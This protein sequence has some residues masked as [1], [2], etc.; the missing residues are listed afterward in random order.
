MSRIISRAESWEKVYTAFQNINFAAFDFN[1]IKQSLLEYIK[2]TFPETFNDYIES[3]ELIAIVESFAYI[4]ELLAYRIDVNAHENFIPTAQR[5]DSV[6][7]L[8]KLVSYTASR[9]LP[10]RGLVKLVSVSTT[11]SVI[12]ANGVDLA[13]QVIRWNDLS[14]VDWKEQFIL[15]INRVLDQQFGSVSPFDRFQIQDVL[16]ELYGVNLI[17][18]QRGVFPYGV[19]VNGNSLSMELVPV[20]YDDTY[21]IVERRPEVN[22]NFTLLYGSD[23]NGDAS[24]TTGF[25]CY[26]K[27]GT[28]QRFAADFDGITPNQVYEINATQI[29]DTDVW[30]NGVNPTTRE[31]VDVPPDFS[32]RIQDGRS[33]EWKQV[34]LAHAQNI[35]FNTNP[36]RNKYEVETRDEN[37]I[38]IIFGDGEF[39]DIPGGSFDIWARSSEDSDVV[40]PQSSVV[41]MPMAFTYVDKFNRTQTF[42]FTFTLINSLQNASASEDLEHIRNTAPAVYYTQDRMVNGEDYNVFMMQDP[43]IMKLRAV[44]RTF[45]GDS[46]YIP[47]H[48]TSQSY[49]NVK[50]FGDDAYL[51]YQTKEVVETTP[52]VDINTLIDGY[53]EPLLSS[54]DIVLQLISAGVSS[55]DIRRVFTSEEKTQ[56]ADTLFPPPATVYLFYNKDTNGWTAVRASDD[57]GSEITAPDGNYI[58]TWLIHIRQPTSLEEIYDVSRYAKRLMAESPTTQFWNTNDADKVIDYN[59]LSSV[60]DQIAILRANSNHTRDGILSQN[61]EFDVLGQEVLD[62]G[63]QDIHRLVVL[64]VDENGDGVPDNLDPTDITNPQGVAEIFT[65]KIRLVGGTPANTNITI[66][67]YFTSSSDIRVYRTDTGADLNYGTN[68]IEILD[69]DNGIGNKV[70]FLSTV[71]TGTDVICEVKEYVYFHRSTTSAPWVAV[72]STYQTLVNYKQDLINLPENR[73]WQRFEGKDQLNFLWTHYSPRYHLVDPSPSNIIDTFVITKGYYTSLQRWLEDPLA[74]TPRTPTP[75]DLRT[76]YNYLLDNKMISDTVI[77]HPGKIKLLFGTRAIPE[78]RATFKVI[79]SQN[80]ILTDNQIKTVVVNT[81]RNFFDI[82]QWEFGE[83]FYFTELAAVIHLAL[84]SDISSV[85]LVP[86]IASNQFGDLFQVLAREDEMF[87]PDITVSQVDIVTSYTSLNMRQTKSTTTFITGTCSGSGGT[88]ARTPYCDLTYCDPEYILENSLAQP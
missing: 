18:V 38:R 23:G 21:G 43:S 33:G 88:S 84:P 45:A 81:I 24:D 79:K 10:A 25:F 9:P 4:A 67:V 62:S 22:S 74:P 70:R 46:K 80:S 49:E 42:S 63:L 48:D 13:N 19:T 76:T 34:D 53:V 40:I 12:D 28:L 35:I 32:F 86:D 73:L 3:S 8:A 58:Q 11:E 66:P 26:T 15:I 61:W 54:P 59:T 36:N 30:V 85:I 44:N 14:N 78:L 75:L 31:I 83:T 2:L 1:T 82:T 17:P 37:K 20:S 65:P 7:R 87:Y 16:F 6:L 55:A 39:A 56:I 72:Q 50:L 5:R 60:R 27:Q 52:I 29:N 71:V 64:P 41:N 68:W 47:W 77:L 57:V 69:V 51:Y